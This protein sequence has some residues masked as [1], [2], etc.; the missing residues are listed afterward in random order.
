LNPDMEYRKLEGIFVDGGNQLATRDKLFVGS[1]AI[2][3]M[4]K[5][6]RNYPAKYETIQANLGIESRPGMSQ[7]ELCKLMI[8]S[9]FPHQ[10]VVIIGYKGRQP[11]FHIDMAMT[12][13]GKPDPETGK[14]V[15][16]VGDPSIAVKMLKDIKRR[17]PEKYARYEAAVNQKVRWSP[18]Q[19][20]D[21]LVNEVGGDKDLQENFDALAKGLERDGYKIE[22]VPY[23]GASSLRNHPWLSYNNAIFDGDKVFIPNFGIEE[24]DKK[25]NDTLKKYGHVPVPI[26]MN[27]ISS[28]QGA[29]NCITKVLE[30]VYT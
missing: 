10:K 15:I 1:D 29:I 4:M 21:R 3:F 30:R 13:L 12:P 23:L 20:L 6:M 17:N 11:S 16:M 5:D 7:E 8:D 2:A 25:A 27:A 19:P 22:R 14:P 26:D 18:E 9:T 28:L 24:L